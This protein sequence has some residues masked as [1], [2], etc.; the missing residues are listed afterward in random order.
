MS[1]CE[2]TDLYEI[3]VHVERDRVL[4]NMFKY[5]V[6][7]TKKWYE[8]VMLTDVERSQGYSHKLHERVPINGLMGVR[9]IGMNADHVYCCTYCL[10]DQRAQ[11]LSTLMAEMDRQIR[12]AHA[13]AT[14][15]L[16]AWMKDQDGI[17]RIKESV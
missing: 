15:V 13:D 12:K 9:R 7:K 14:D 11:A 1:R 17:A 8:R 16:Q 10:K 3:S 6:K 2:L 4:A 5:R